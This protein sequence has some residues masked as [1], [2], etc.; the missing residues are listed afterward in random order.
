MRRPKNID[1]ISWAGMGENEREA[2]IVRE[3]MQRVAQNRYDRAVQQLQRHYQ[4]RRARIERRYEEDQA[5]ARAAYR[6]IE[7]RAFA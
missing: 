5:A 6:E 1:A 7:D 4:K 2:T 3:R